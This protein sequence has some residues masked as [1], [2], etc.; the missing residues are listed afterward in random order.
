MPGRYLKYKAVQHWIHFWDH[1]FKQWQRSLPLSTQTFTTN[2]LKLNVWPSD[3]AKIS[4]F[5]F[6]SSPPKVFFSSLHCFNHFLEITLT[7]PLTL[8]TTFTSFFEC[9]T[10]FSKWLIAYYMWC[11]TQLVR[12]SSSAYLHSLAV[13]ILHFHQHFMCYLFF[14]HSLLKWSM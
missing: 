9:L 8:S 12:L 1:I 7:Y 2:I 14:H 3:L 5:S 4:A 11:L 6:I 13:Q 10:G